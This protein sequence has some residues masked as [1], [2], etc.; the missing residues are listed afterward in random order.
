MPN[1]NSNRKKRLPMVALIGADGSGKSSV[2]DFLSENFKH[3]LVREIF[4]LYDIHNL[5]FMDKKSD[6]GKPILNY[7]KPP[8]SNLY[9]F[10]K[11]NIMAF[12]WVLKFYFEIAPMKRSGTL[13]LCDHFYFLGMAL[14][15]LKYRYGGNLFWIKLL[16]GMVPQPDIYILL[17]VPLDI[18][19]G[20]RQEATR[21]EVNQLLE[22]HREYILSNP[23]GY[24]VNAANPVEQVAAD[25]SRIIVQEI[26]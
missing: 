2:L 17:D 8:H 26:E 24:V 3:D 1:K 4:I 14:D 15:P 6:P 9:S 16:L 25:V 5:K 19:Y 18:V 22:R 10:A 23:H 13:I 12:L 21:D 11:L 20:R 7:E